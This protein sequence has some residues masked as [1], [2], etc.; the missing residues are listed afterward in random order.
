MET[1]LQNVE[2]L[3]TAE[4]ERAICLKRLRY[5]RFNSMC[6]TIASRLD[7]VGFRDCL[8]ISG[9]YS[10]NMGFCAQPGDIYDRLLEEIRTALRDE[11]IKRYSHTFEELRVVAE[12]ADELI[13]LK[14]LE[15]DRDGQL[16]EHDIT[17]E[18]NPASFLRRISQESHYFILVDNLSPAT[19]DVL[20]T[21]LH[22]PPIIFL[23]HISSGGFIEHQ[24]SEIGYFDGDCPSNC[25]H[26]NELQR[27]ETS[28]AVQAAQETGYSLTWR[29]LSEI[30]QEGYKQ[31]RR[32]LRS[33][34][35]F[36]RSATEHI[37]PDLERPR[38]EDS[39]TGYVMSRVYRGYHLLDNYRRRG[40]LL[41]HFI[42]RGVDIL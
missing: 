17:Q 27:L 18:D 40:I 30:G 12:N 8:A 41:T 11:Q 29:R 25:D 7:E 38:N 42:V 2:Q 3:I 16:K 34:R 9:Y 31:E 24:V 14:V 33:C 36:E 1:L 4:K 10:R 5:R 23:R 28:L 22:V 35:R 26:T 15:V 6:T 39:R 37:V 32:A 19:T 13:D 20:G 21:C